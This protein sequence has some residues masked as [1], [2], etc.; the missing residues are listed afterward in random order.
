MKRQLGRTHDAFPNESKLS[1]SDS[2]LSDEAY[3]KLLGMMHDEKNTDMSAERF[4]S[5]MNALNNQIIQ[6]AGN[7]LTPE[8]LIEFKGAIK[9]S[10]EITGNG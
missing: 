4:S 10:S 5:N 3:R 9:T 7:M 6:Q 2:P 8:Q 1:T